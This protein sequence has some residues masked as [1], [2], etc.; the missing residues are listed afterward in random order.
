MTRRN[1]IQNERDT[2]AANRA[3]EATALGTV[4]GSMIL[5][6]LLPHRSDAKEAVPHRGQDGTIS[7]AD[8]HGSPFAAGHHDAAAP[9]LSAPATH[10]HSDM[11]GAVS[12]IDAPAR[13][14]EDGGRLDNGS[15]MH[16]PSGASPSD[17]A[18]QSWAAPG[19]LHTGA[20][21]DDQHGDVAPH[22]VLSETSPMGTAMA[23]AWEMVNGTLFHVGDVIDTALS[24]VSHSLTESFA[25]LSTTISGITQSL[26]NPLGIGVENPVEAILHNATLD[27]RHDMSFVHLA[28]GQPDAISPATPLAL[29]ASLPGNVLGAPD[30]GMDQTFGAPETLTGMHPSIASF[31]DLSN[32]I[33]VSFAGQGLT[34]LADG[35]DLSTHGTGSLFHGLV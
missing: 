30:G 22:A 26:A 19:I 3:V 6:A 34:H 8:E 7:V 1:R 29:L 27:A 20:L 18:A 16:L 4:A 31:G 9:G 24:S 35:H 15:S 17:G 33:H 32:P 13:G 2:A 12:S 28:D 5:G 11:T 23:E 25:S 14:S 21:P 10:G